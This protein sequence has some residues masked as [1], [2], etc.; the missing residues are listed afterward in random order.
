MDILITEDI[1]AEAFDR[2]AERYRVLRDGT[3][4]NDSARLRDGIRDVR[5]VII[6]NQTRVTADLLAD[7]PKLLAIGR[8]GVGLDNID[9]DATSKAGIVVIAPLRSEER[10]VGKECR[11]RWSAEH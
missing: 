8:H 5:T 6:R 4:W 2:L 1:K 11:S 9:M 7:A 10:R 3:L